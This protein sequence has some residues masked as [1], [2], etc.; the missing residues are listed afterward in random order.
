M[1]NTGT[2]IALSLAGSPRLAALV[3]GA[4]IFAASC[5]SGDGAGARPSDPAAAAS[6]A[7]D[8]QSTQPASG[9]GAAT[10]SDDEEAGDEGE[11]DGA[12][13][14]PPDL[15]GDEPRDPTTMPGA[16]INQ[17]VLNIDQ[18]FDRIEDL[19]SG[20]TRIIT[21]LLPCSSSHRFQIF[22]R[23]DYPAPH[24]SLYPGD[25]TMENFALDSCYLRFEDWAGIAYE[26]SELEIGVLTPDRENFEDELA[27]YRGIHCWVGAVDGEPL[28][29]TARGSEI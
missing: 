12:T 23:L 2:A 7:L 14:L 21:T 3:A 11:P 18:C 28:V 10:T 25:G 1:L 24:P 16:V 17:Y 19:V 4:A 26:I 6:A 15:S 22:G 29:G 13:T 9:P 27:A 5:G 8:E 20:R